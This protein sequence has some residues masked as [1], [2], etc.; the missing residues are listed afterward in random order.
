[1]PILPAEI[2]PGAPPACRPAQGLRASGFTHGCAQTG[3]SAERPLLQ[4]KRHSAFIPDYPLPTRTRLLAEP[5]PFSDAPSVVNVKQFPQ[6]KNV[7]TLREGGSHDVAP[8]AGRSMVYDPT[9]GLPC[10]ASRGMEADAL[11]AWGHLR[12][13]KDREPATVVDVL[14]G[15]IGFAS[16]CDNK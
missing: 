5:G 11:A 9:T 8:R 16:P 12:R 4:G 2:L 1:M 15:G 10:R 6:I 14:R 3:T 13:V 7:E